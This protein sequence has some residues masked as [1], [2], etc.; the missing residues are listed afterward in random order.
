M[1]PDWLS[2]EWMTALKLVAVAVLV[3]ING[4]FVASEFALVA[5]R[6]SRVEQLVAEG[7]ATGP[8]LK[9]ATEHLDAYLAA[10]QLGITLV[11]LALG[12]IGEPA[13]SHVIEPLL[14]FLPGPLQTA[15]S[16]GAAIVIA[17]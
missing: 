7:H 12:W 6:R 1:L 2:F 17:F 14:N 8:L 16:H 15:A 4:F 9:E 5:I 11:S 13:L 3:F 10:T